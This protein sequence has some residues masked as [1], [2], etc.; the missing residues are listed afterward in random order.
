MGSKV[1]GSTDAHPTKGRTKYL[2]FAHSHW[3]TASILP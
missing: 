1:N 3:K 2:S